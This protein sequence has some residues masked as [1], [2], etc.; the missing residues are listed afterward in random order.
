M[1]DSIR[2]WLVL[3]EKIPVMITWYY[4]VPVKAGIVANVPVPA[5]A[6]YLL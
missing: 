5:L 3:S 6:G 1:S 4:S 2:T